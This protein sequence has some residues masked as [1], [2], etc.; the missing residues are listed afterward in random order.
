MKRAAFRLLGCAGL[1]IAAST[2]LVVPAQGTSEV[3]PEVSA[4]KIVGSTYSSGYF[5]FSLTIPNAWSAY[6][7]QGRRLLLDK[8]YQELAARTPNEKTQDALNKGVANT[9]VLL[10]VSRLPRDQAGTGN[11]IFA[12]GAE[13]LPG[14]SFTGRDYLIAMKALMLGIKDP[15]TLEGDI[16]SETIG[17]A[18]FAVL[19]LSRNDFGALIGQRYWSIVKKGYALFC[20]STYANDDDKRL[21]NQTMSSMKFQPERAN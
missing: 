12:C 10:T 11:A 21:L 18:E 6:D 1:V 13:R 7:A 17:G 4:G 9:V 20:I 5:G 15:P 3:P 14:G 19:T 2:F 8:G 16:G